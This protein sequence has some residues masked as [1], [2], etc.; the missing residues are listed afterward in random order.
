MNE[1]FRSDRKRCRVTMSCYEWI[2]D[3]DPISDPEPI[4]PRRRKEKPSLRRYQTREPVQRTSSASP[5]M[6]KISGVKS[7]LLS[8]QRGTEG[9]RLQHL[10]SVLTTLIGLSEAER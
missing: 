6:S 5:F 4:V 1:V 9:Q 10:H 3:N 8:I 2:G 7:S